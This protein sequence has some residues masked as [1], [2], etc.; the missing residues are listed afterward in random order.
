MNGELGFEAALTERVATL[1]GLETAVIDTVFNE[2]ITFTPGG[3]ELV[4]TMRAHGARCALVSG[5]FTAFTHRVAET[6]GFTNTA[7][8]RSSKPTVT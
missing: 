1:K 8:T 6:L 5:G 2:R 3:R 7:P 4:S